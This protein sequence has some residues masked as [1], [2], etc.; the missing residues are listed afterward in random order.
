MAG[1][2][3]RTLG[4]LT[5][6]HADLVSAEMVAEVRAAGA[7]PIADYAVRE[8]ATV[9]GAISSVTVNPRDGRRWLEIELTDGS[10]VVT[11]IWMGRRMIPGIEPGRGL[12]ARGRITL[13]DGRKAIFNPH[14][15]LR[16]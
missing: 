4:R 12:T 15:E 10:D 8:V 16:D 14:Y 11:L 9:T 5:T 7:R 2:L 6:P 1:R 13:A 3:R